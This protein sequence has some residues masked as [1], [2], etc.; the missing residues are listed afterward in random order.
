MAIITHSGMQKFVN[1]LQ[2]LWKD[3]IRDIIKTNVC[4]FFFSTVL[5]KMVYILSTRQN[6]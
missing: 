5:S 1:P 4:Y 6:N 2:N 3:I